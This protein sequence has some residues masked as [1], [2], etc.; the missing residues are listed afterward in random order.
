MRRSLTIE[1]SEDEFQDF[2]VQAG[3]VCST[4]GLDVNTFE[5]FSCPQRITIEAKSSNTLTTESFD[6]KNCYHSSLTEHYRCT[7]ENPRWHEN[8]VKALRE[9]NMIQG[10]SST[11]KIIGG[12]SKMLLEE[13]NKEITIRYTF[14]GDDETSA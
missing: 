5:V 8:L 13:F 9:V 14:E 12:D 4:Q 2:L 10:Y 6:P 11:I 3:I 7:I 1:M